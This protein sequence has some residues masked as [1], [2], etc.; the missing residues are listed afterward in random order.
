MG[1][2]VLRAA[3]YYRI[4]KDLD[5]EQDA[6]TR[7][8][9]DCRTFAKLRNAT[10]VDEF[11]DVDLSAYQK[12]VIRPGYEELVAGV[13]AGEFDVV[14]VWRLD[15]LVR[16]TVEFARFWTACETCGLVRV[17]I[18]RE[19]YVRPLGHPGPHAPTRAAKPRAERAFV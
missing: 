15:R 4:S 5:G 10:I 19:R 2:T 8:R 13:E 18:G 12:G 6:T 11:E 9:K 16:R 7:Q 1:A 14:I 17:A 3:T